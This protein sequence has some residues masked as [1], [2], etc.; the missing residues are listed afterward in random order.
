MQVCPELSSF[1]MKPANAE[2]HSSWRKRQDFLTRSRQPL[3][4]NESWQYVSM[5][6]PGEF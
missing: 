3:Q 1:Y 6:G 5:S 2:D 4:G